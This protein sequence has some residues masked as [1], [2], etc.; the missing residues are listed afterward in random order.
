MYSGQPLQNGSGKSSIEDFFLGHE[1]ALL[2]FSCQDKQLF[3]NIW[4]VEIVRSSRTQ[5]IIV[6]AIHLNQIILPQR[7][8][9]HQFKG[10][11]Y[12]LLSGK[13][14][15]DSGMLRRLLILEKSLILF[16]NFFIAC[17]V[18]MPHLQCGICSNTILL[19]FR[20]TN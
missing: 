19:H 2:F 11:N 18:K 1:R 13:Y 12:R 16:L 5:E 4:D 7:I 10:Q 9:E 6:G 8:L 3:R 20:I 17:C 15:F 14:L